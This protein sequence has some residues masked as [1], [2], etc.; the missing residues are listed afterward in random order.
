MV[1]IPKEAFQV[2]LLQKEHAM[3]TGRE[4]MVYNDQ[5]KEIIQHLSLKVSQMPF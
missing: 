3:R 2:G 1:R 4:F 5:L